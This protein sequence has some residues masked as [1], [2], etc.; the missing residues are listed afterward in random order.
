MNT[1][2]R[3]LALLTLLISVTGCYT[4][5]NGSSGDEAPR[6]EQTPAR[7][8]RLLDRT[9]TPGP[10]PE[11]LLAQLRADLRA[12]RGDDGEA[13]LVRAESVTWPDGALGCPAPGITYTQALVPGYQVVF[14]ADGGRWDYR[15][16][17]G[18]AFRLC[19]ATVTP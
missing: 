8:E 5:G 18:G 2:M 19:G 6:S 3:N 12:R 13:R 9:G 16:G 7:F 14:E 11:A 15:V 17:A 1:A 10:V 4:S